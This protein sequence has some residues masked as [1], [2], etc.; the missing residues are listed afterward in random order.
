MPSTEPTVVSRV[1]AFVMRLPAEGDA[2]GVAKAAAALTSIA[3]VS[4]GSAAA[5]AIKRGSD[6]SGGAALARPARGTA[7][8]SA[9]TVPTGLCNL[10][11]PKSSTLTLNPPR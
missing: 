10:A 8:A 11:M 1:N 7:V 5:D 9:E 6:S 3:T 2:E 4:A